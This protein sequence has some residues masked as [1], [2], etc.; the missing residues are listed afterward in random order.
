MN[1]G[2][3]FGSCHPIRYRGLPLLGCI[4]KQKIYITDCVC[5]PC[6]GVLVQA[7]PSQAE[8]FPSAS[9]LNLN[10]INIFIDFVLGA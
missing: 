3:G 7:L 10:T 4:L 8:D 9:F 1:F 6:S 2:V 5:C